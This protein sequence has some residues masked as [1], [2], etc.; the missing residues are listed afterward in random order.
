MNSENASL[1][2]TLIPNDHGKM[3]NMPDSQTLDYHTPDKS[4]STYRILLYAP[5]LLGAL[6][7]PWLGVLLRFVDPTHNPH[8]FPP[9]TGMVFEAIG[10]APAFFG[11]IIGVYVLVRARKPSERARGCALLGIALCATFLVLILLSLFMK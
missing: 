7:G 8:G 4:E 11:L 2:A 5:L 10:F 3:S 9:W 6:E 1:S